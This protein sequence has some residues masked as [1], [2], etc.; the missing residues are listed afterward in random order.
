MGGCVG[1]SP[2][3]F[4]KEDTMSNPY[5]LFQTDQKLESNGVTLD[6]GAF[7]ITIARA[8]MGN[9]KY[10]GLLATSLNKHR[11]MIDND[12]LDNSMHDT[13]MIGIYADAIILGWANVTG[14]DGKALAFN[15]ANAVKLMTDLPDLFADIREQAKNARNFRKS[16]LA[17]A[18]K[19]LNATSATA[20]E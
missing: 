10:R 12:L 5:E 15:R 13:L 1:R 3:T 20:S 2:I 9:R 4:P 17:D 19:N 7:Q 18:E 8:G 16:E 14:A 11:H 6:Y